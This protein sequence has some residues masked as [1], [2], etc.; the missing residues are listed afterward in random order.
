LAISPIGIKKQKR[1]IRSIQQQRNTIMYPTWLINA[2]IDN[3]CAKCRHPIVLDDITAIALARPEDYAAHLREPFALIVAECRKCGQKHSFQ[4]RCAKDPLFEAMNH[5]AIEI[6]SAPTKNPP[7]FG[8]GSTANAQ[9]NHT[10]SDENQ[11][12][13]IRPSLRAGQKTS[14][15]S[16]EEVREFLARLKRMSFKP[17]SSSFKKLTGNGPTKPSEDND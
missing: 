14:P 6:E 17:G 1:L 16:T 9:R 10:V 13:Q 15:L 7:P 5:L 11:R 8:P 12:E 4:M 3:F 2:F